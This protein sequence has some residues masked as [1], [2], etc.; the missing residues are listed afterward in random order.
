[1]VIVTHK[2]YD[3]VLVGTR[4]QKAPESLSE[5]RDMDDGADATW[6]G[7]RNRKHPRPTVDRQTDGTFRGWKV[8]DRRRRLD[9]LSATLQPNVIE[10]CFPH[11]AIGKISLQIG[12]IIIVYFRRPF[13][14]F[15]KTCVRRS[16]TALKHT[17][18]STTSHLYHVF[19]FSALF[20]KS[21]PDIALVC[22]VASFSVLR[23]GRVEVFYLSNNLCMNVMLFSVYLMANI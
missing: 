17:T 21:C 14:S 11:A 2:S 18:S 13:R 6:S 8:E 5:N 9:V 4:K 10:V 16:P 23:H 19:L 15:V 20:Q 7:T 22:F 1:M 3:S 12:Y